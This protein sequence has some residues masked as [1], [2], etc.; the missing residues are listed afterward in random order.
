MD[1]NTRENELAQLTEAIRQFNA[2][3][4]WEQFH[5]PENLAKSVAIEA[6]ELL[7][8][9][10]WSGNYK[11][12]AVREEIADVMM[13]C[14]MLC[15]KAGIDPIE[16]MW[17]KYKKNGEKYPVEKAKGLAKKYTELNN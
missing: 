3:R 1:N 12:E 11:P 9:F 15:D 13:Y 17:D 6:G 14:L 4:D 16:A 10:Q 5:S 2:E 7:E 8:C